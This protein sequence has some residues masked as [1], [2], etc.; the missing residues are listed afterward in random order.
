M[1]TI[2]FPFDSMVTH[3]AQT[4]EPIYDRAISSDPLRMLIKKMFSTGVDPNDSQALQVSSGTGMYVTVHSG[5]C[6]IEGGMKYEDEERTL[7]LQAADS[8]NPRIDTVVMRW[9]S[10]IAVRE[11]DLY[12]LT[13]TPAASP[14]RPELT[15]TESYYEI[16]LADILVNA[17]M[18]M[19]ADYLITDTRYET[20]RCGV[21][22]PIAEIDTD[23]I[24]QQVQ[25]DLANFKA[26]E[27][28]E[29]IV[30]FNYMKDQLSEDAAGHLQNEIDGILAQ[31]GGYK[32]V[33]TTI[34]NK[35]HDANTIYFCTQ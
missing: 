29:F 12:V 4:G 19:M 20:G 24:Y 30:W 1:S 31:L 2:G 8:V 14:T 33:K 25:A 35:G 22:S 3:D 5:F 26:E 21:V 16:G 23:T 10:N 13:G 18:S 27:Q 7:A 32:L 11:C 15:R 6:I 28:A 34:A 9:N 17:N